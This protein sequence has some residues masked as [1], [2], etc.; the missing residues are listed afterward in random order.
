MTQLLWRAMRF[1]ALAMAGL[2]I[3]WF[4]SPWILPRVL[5]ADAVAIGPWRGSTTTG[6]IDAG[7]YTRARVARTGLLALNRAETVY[8]EASVDDEG[9]PLRA[10]CTYDVTGGPIAARWWSITAYADD[11]FLFANSAR[12]FSHTLKTLK[13]DS[14]GRYAILIGPAPRERNWLP[15]GEKG[16]GFNLL[17]RL[18]NPDVLVATEPGQAVL[19]GIKRV[20]GCAA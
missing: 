5:S 11:F 8:F 18:Y 14:D 2:A 10:G 13:T 6:G 7:P 1:A 15:T 20:G 16:G 17:L 12:R 3:G 19:P 4:A 9:R